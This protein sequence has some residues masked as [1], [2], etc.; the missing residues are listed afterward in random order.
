MGNLGV[1]G[2]TTFHHWCAEEGLSCNKSQ[3]DKTG[4]DYLVEFPF[5]PESKKNDVHISALECKVQ[6]KA[7]N[8]KDRKLPITLSNLRR[9]VTSQLPAFYVFI[10][11]DG[12]NTAQR[13]FVV[14]VDEQLATKVLK[15]LH[16]IEQSDSPNNFNKRTMTISY[17]DSHLLEKANGRC[18]KD[19]IV[20]Y[21]G[22]NLAEYVAK[23]K[24]HLE[25][26]GF[27]NGVSRMNFQI[28]GMDNIERFIDM[29]LGIKTKANITNLTN[30]K[31]RFGID[32]NSPC[33]EFDAGT[34]EMPD[35]KPVAKGTVCFRL[36][37]ID[38]GVSFEAELYLSQL[39]PFLADELKKFRVKGDFFDIVCQPS[40]GKVEFSFSFKDTSLRLEK[41]SDAIKLFASFSIPGKKHFVDFDFKGMPKQRDVIQCDGFEHDYGEELKYV[42]CAR[43]LIWDFDITEDV[44]I[45]FRELVDEGAKICAL[46][47]MISN[48]TRQFEAEFSAKLD[49]NEHCKEAAFITLSKVSIGNFALGALIVIVGKLEKIGSEKFRLTSNNSVVERKLVVR[50]GERICEEDMLAIIEEIENKYEESYTVITTFKKH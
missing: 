46:N 15:R 13:A 7:T 47:D 43:N 20:K 24:A 48:S 21:I 16:K 6:V 31:T 37:G 29:S 1:M 27:E 25:S 9:L 30:I 19:A 33:I 22:G 23:K 8:K 41:L 14:H 35:I 34:L 50:Q 18:L 40:K 45:S 3:E 2:E 17:D 39:G 12:E 49:E 44:Y 42:E 11:F 4:W 10:E 28:Q 26:T 36:D 38:K 5:D 32:N